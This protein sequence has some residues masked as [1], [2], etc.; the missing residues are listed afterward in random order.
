M[1]TRP[2]V[3][4]EPN[5][6]KKRK[7]IFRTEEDC[8]TLSEWTETGSA[9]NADASSS[10]LRGPPSVPGSSFETV[11]ESSL[12]LVLKLLS[13]K[14]GSKVWKV[15]RA[16]F[17]LLV[18]TSSKGLRESSK[19]TCSVLVRMTTVLVSK[20]DPRWDRKVLIFQDDENSTYNALA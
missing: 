15:L 16:V 12:R 7:N 6:E 14:W 20:T 18:E 5:C 9:E 19:R 1:N 13:F 3:S 8:V 17:S 2:E 4:R 10:D 11:A